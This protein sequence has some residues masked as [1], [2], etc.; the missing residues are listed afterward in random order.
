MASDIY[1]LEP[2]PVDEGNFWEKDS[3]EYERRLN[4]ITARLENY[5]SNFKESVDYD[6]TRLNEK[7]TQAQEELKQAMEKF[8]KGELGVD[9]VKNYAVIL[10]N[11]FK[12]PEQPKNLLS[13][14]RKKAKPNSLSKEGYLT[15]S[16]YIDG[17]RKTSGDP[18]HFWIRE[19]NKRLFFAG[20]KPPPGVTSCMV[21]G[22]GGFDPEGNPLEQYEAE[23]RINQEV[24]ELL[25]KTFGKQA[26]SKSGQEPEQT[27]E[28][29]TAEIGEIET[30]G[31]TLDEIKKE[32][33][34]IKAE[35]NLRK[36]RRK[37]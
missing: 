11:S 30:K 10:R 23:R 15:G 36:G 1:K 3:I 4:Y 14:A 35:K 37:N 20:E 27:G 29:K 32:S 7:V 12:R 34:H 31:K 16:F 21:E 8:A 17:V 6:F 33:D 5:L 22:G 2:F 13:Q 18:L 28:E 24:T 9:T 25:E 19:N 26:Y